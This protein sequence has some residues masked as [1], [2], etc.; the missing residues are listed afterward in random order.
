M[1]IR[2]KA[3]YRCSACGKIVMRQ[4]SKRWIKSFCDSTGKNVHIWRQEKGCKGTDKA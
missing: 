1:S 2:L 4:S 3:A